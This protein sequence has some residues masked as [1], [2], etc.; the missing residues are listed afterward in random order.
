MLKIIKPTLLLDKKKC[1]RNIF[2]MANKAKRTNLILRPHF[3]TH[4]SAEIGNWFRDYGVNSITVSSASMAK[5]FADDWNDITIAFPVN[6]LE[7]DEINELADEINLNILVESEEVV[8]NLSRQ[9]TSTVGA[10]IK[11]DTDYN[12]TGIHSSNV[13]AINS[14]LKAIEAS[15]KILFKGFLTHAGHTYKAESQEELSNI[16]RKSINQLVSLK[17]MYINDYD[18]IILSIGDTPACTS[19]DMF[20]GVDEIRPGNFIFY[21]VMQYEKGIC[22]ASQIAVC[23]ACPVVSVHKDRQEAVIYGGGIHLS[24]ESI[25]DKNRNAFYGLIVKLNNEG[26]GEPLKD[27]YVKSL[28]QEHGIIK[29]SEAEL[30]Q[31]SS[32]SILGILPVHSC[33]TANL[34]KEYLTLN[35][36]KISMMR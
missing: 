29:M 13:K 30:A 2:F 34:M 16:H 10:F 4:Q 1:S 20:D 21:D 8:K 25:A 32:G 35:N 28:S 15:D 24:K 17:E 7:A 12:R 14:V 33:L 18:K 36:Q 9:L 22:S 19:E 23:L 5:Y 11:I 6:I 3:K 26:W 31:I 27:C